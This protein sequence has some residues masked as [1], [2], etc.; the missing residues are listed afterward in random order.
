[1]SKEILAV[2]EAVSNEKGV[3]KDIIFGAIEAALA[4]AAAKKHEEDIEAR[5]S[6][7]RKT[8]EHETFRRWLVF[9]D[10]STELEFPGHELRM[11]DAVDID[12]TAEPGGYV[13]IPIDSVE[14]G[15]I[16]AQMAKQVIVQ[17]VREAE[18]NQVI[19][20]YQGREGELLSGLV[21][22]VDRNGVYIDLGGNAEG[23]ISRD[24]MMPREAVRMH[25]RVK[26]L[27]VEVRSEP[28]GPQLF[29]TRTSPQFLIELFK[30]EV[31]EVGQGLIEILGA[32]RDPG[33][34]AKISVK[35]NESRIDPVGACVGIRGSRVQSV[36]NELSGERVDIILWN[37]NPAQYVINSMSPAE[38]LSIVVDEDANSM[39][40]AVDEEK[41]SQAIGRGG[42]NI[43]LASELTGWE[44][45][46]MTEVDAD[47]KN[48]KETQDLINLFT[49]QLD[50][51]EEVALILVQEGFASV[52]EVAYVPVSELVQ[53]EE[54]D[55][56]IV[57]ELRNRA[58]D[59]LLTQAIV[60]EEEIENAEPAEDLLN[61]EGMN[62][63]LA[64]KLASKGI[65]TR[66]DLAELAS[67][68]LLEIEKMKQES[69]DSLIMNAR[70]HW[71]DEAKE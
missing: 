59:V 32:A 46:V 18:R 57:D 71:F 56:D 42:Q 65:V 48:E 7:D 63:T 21:K 2:V 66:E 26:A 9:E 12:K 38:V 28:R 67:D 41:L 49:S 34:R 13:E 8:G 45:N 33:L 44:L 1:M 51:D 40:V 53:I 11:I 64:S 39:D 23:F 14:F 5:V 27:L 31:P 22:R 24:E 50:V 30:I 62:K 35:S 68:D 61:L 19:E 6:I 25:D 58:R 43:R 37:E 60:A 29:M 3:E 4:T 15:R 55:A 36:S 54:F 17:K 47:K 10:D 16:S 70:A 52:E 69:A 20:E